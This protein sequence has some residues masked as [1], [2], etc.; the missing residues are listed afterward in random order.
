MRLMRMPNL[1]GFVKFLNN[2][3]P[4]ET[5]SKMELKYKKGELVKVCNPPETDEDRTNSYWDDRDDHL[6]GRIGRIV[7]VDDTD[8]LLTYYVKFHEL[9]GDDIDPSG[10][11]HDRWYAEENLKPAKSWERR[12]YENEKS[13]TSIS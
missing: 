13:K 12:R 9:A 5:K 11:S 10:N 6:V 3:S 4:I 2:I 1:K 8:E 7:D